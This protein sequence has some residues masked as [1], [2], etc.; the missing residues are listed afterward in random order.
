MAA[1]G[2]LGSER[3]AGGA[4]A[5]SCPAIVSTDVAMRVTGVEEV[6]DVDEGK[7]D[8]CE[9]EDMLMQKEGK[10]AK[11]RDQVQLNFF[12]LVRHSFRQRMDRQEHDTGKHDGPYDDHHRDVVEHVGVTRRSDK[13]RQMFCRY[14]IG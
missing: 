7:D 10:Q 4:A 3:S 5:V 8:G 13:E 6:G 14:W 1:F 9:P 2:G 11:Y 12:R